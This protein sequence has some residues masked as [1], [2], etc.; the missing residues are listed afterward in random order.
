VVV[1]AATTANHEASTN[2]RTNTAPTSRR[3]TPNPRPVCWPP[4]PESAAVPT[5]QLPR[6]P[7]G[8]EVYRIPPALT[9]P[10]WSCRPGVGMTCAP[11]CSRPATQRATAKTSS[12][13]TWPLAPDLPGSSQRDH[14]SGSAPP[15]NP[16]RW[17]LRLM[18]AAGGLHEVPPRAGDDHPSPRRPGAAC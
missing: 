3:P 6:R 12:P 9:Q 8:A 4:K 10:L 11:K 7:K 5:R 13:L 18:A 15:C 2:Y 14:P 17:T 1:T 16:L